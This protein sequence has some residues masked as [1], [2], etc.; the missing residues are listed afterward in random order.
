VSG[1]RVSALCVTNRPACEPWLRWN[2]LRQ[3]Y[4]NLD[5]VVVDSSRQA[6]VHHHRRADVLDP[7]S[8]L[9]RIW[10]APGYASRAVRV[11]PALFDLP[12]GVLR[13]IAM[14]FARGEYFVWF[15]DDDWQHPERVEWLVEVIEEVGSLW[16]GWGCG[17]ILELPQRRGAFLPSHTPR[18][19]N[20]AAIY[21]TEAARQVAYDDG[22]T[23]SDA[24]WLRQLAQ[25]YGDSGHVLLDQRLHAIWLRHGANTSQSLRGTPCGLVLDWFKNKAG[26]AWGQTDAHLI[27]LEQALGVAV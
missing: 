4:K 1:P 2:V 3:T 8:A 21:R 10:S 18:V 7:T 13:N 9:D 25:H 15:D 23:A 14:L 5:I 19:I 11:V 16:A 24:R 17:H 27:H 22:P 12:C 26:A 20:G 6:E